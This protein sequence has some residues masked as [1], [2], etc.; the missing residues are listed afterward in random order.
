MRHTKSFALAIVNHSGTSNSIKQIFYQIHEAK[1][2]VDN[3]AWPENDVTD[4]QMALDRKR[5]PTPGMD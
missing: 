2:S 5:L 1:F 3:F 4:I